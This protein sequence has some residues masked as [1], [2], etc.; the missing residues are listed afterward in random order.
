MLLGDKGDLMIDSLEANGMVQEVRALFIRHGTE[1]FDKLHE[2]LSR[3][4]ST[5][6]NLEVEHDWNNLFE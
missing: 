3:T 5:I 1:L 6:S 2:S 4:N